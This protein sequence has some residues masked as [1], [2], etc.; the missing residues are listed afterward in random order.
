MRKLNKLTYFD[1]I[2]QTFTWVDNLMRN[3]TVIALM[4]LIDG[5]T[6]VI[7]PNA[8]VN[9][10]ARGVAFTVAIAAVT[11]L[12]GAIF[13]K[14]KTKKTVITIC[15]SSIVIALC[16]AMY[17]WPKVPSAVLTYLLAIIIIS[18]GVSN[19]LHTLKLE[20]LIA[21]RKVATDRLGEIDR[22]IQDKLPDDEITQSI[23]QGVYEQISKR[24]DPV[25]ELKSRFGMH[26]A[27]EI[28]IDFL[29][30]IAG[31]LILFFPW[32]FG[33]QLM[34]I[35]GVAMFIAASNSLWITLRAHIHKRKVTLLM[36]LASQSVT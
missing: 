9:G 22:E 28:V 4:L 10:L 21:R 31:V 35:C 30:I 33:V 2:D 6:F 24:L 1:K 26:S 27:I 15:S 18:D 11:M 13:E 25:N 29:A 12:F 20:T 34:R 36:Y 7:T 16:A 14:K 23:Q 3:K 17:I 5:I 8:G 19:V 32:L